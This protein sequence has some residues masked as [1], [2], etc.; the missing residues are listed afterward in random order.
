MNKNSDGGGAG[1]TYKQMKSYGQTDAIKVCQMIA[2]S[3]VF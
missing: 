3:F 2:V 1:Q